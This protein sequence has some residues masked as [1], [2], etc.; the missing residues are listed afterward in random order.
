MT[1]AHPAAAPCDD[2]DR[3][4]QLVPGHG[5]RGLYPPPLPAGET[6]V[7]SGNG[8]ETAATLRVEGRKSW[9]IGH[10]VCWHRPAPRYSRAPRMSTGYEVLAVNDVPSCIR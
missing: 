9:R 5:R 1:E 8:R 3:R 4:G 10:A 7:Q 6:S 2:G